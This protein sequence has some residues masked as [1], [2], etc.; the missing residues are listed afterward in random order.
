MNLKNTIHSNLILILI[1]FL[2]T[3]AY[4]ENIRMFHIER[5]KNS[6]IVCYDLEVNEDKK[7]VSGNPIRAYWEMPHK[8]NTTNSLSTVQYKLAYGFTIDE[9]EENMLSFKLKAY[10]ERS[11]KV[12]YD[13][14]KNEAKTFT[15]IDGVSAILNKLYIQ[16]LPPF[17]Q[18][19]EYII[20]SGI[21]IL[22]G[23]TVTE[24]ISN[25]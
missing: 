2:S 6:S 13:P 19:V 4:A 8:G 20:L 15:I 17:Y 16:A 9:I 5:N 7:I 10:P 22:T 14:E 18:S 1:L 21:N 3:G 24:Q 23:E 12:V 11:L 25:K